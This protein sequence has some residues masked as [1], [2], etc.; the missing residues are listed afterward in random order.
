M[1]GLRSGFK[2]LEGVVIADAAF[3][4][5]GSS[6]EELFEAAATALFEIMVDTKSVELKVER[7]FELQ[8]ESVEGLLYDFLSYLIF[9]KDAE[10]LLLS[11]F[12]IK[13]K[14]NGGYQLSAHVYGE[15]IDMK[16]H[17]LRIDVKAITYYLF[18][19]KRVGDEWVAM[20]VV[21]V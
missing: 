6:L 13:I 11:R 3:K 12:D 5:W 17:E 4:A 15:Q 1:R 8:N 9:L 19:V 18:E 7:D 16:K 21:D 2:F 20:V 10:M 14:G